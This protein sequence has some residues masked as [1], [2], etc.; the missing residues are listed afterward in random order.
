[1]K[2]HVHPT[3]PTRIHIR[4]WV[5]D[6]LNRLSGGGGKVWLAT[7]GLSAFVFA[8]VTKVSPDF[9]MKGPLSIV[10][11]RLYQGRVLSL[12]GVEVTRLVVEVMLVAMV[13]LESHYLMDTLSNMIRRISC[14]IC[15]TK[16]ETE[17]CVFLQ[18]ADSCETDSVL[19][20]WEQ[21][22]SCKAWQLV[23]KSTSGSWSLKGCAVLLDHFHLIAVVTFG[24]LEHSHGLVI[25]HADV[26]TRFV[27]QS[28]CL[29]FAAK[30]ALMLALDDQPGAIKQNSSNLALWISI[31]LLARI[32]MTLDFFHKSPGSHPDYTHTPAC[33]HTPT[34][35]P[36]MTHTH[37]GETMQRQIGSILLPSPGAETPNSVIVDQPAVIVPLLCLC[38]VLSLS[39]LL[40]RSRAAVSFRR[41]YDQLFGAES[42]EAFEDMRKVILFGQL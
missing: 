11:R 4:E 32:D 16:T 39:G 27:L 12:D 25:N 35:S 22:E 36:V 17:T 26:T 28:L 3:I 6:E 31:A 7:A 15:S 30:P 10:V 24:I 13:V 14:L 18:E 38:L 21:M 33:T 8:V 23:P 5:V 2:S 1:M 9:V 37:T 29:Y 19:A 34:H 40:Q 42:P 20:R 41:L